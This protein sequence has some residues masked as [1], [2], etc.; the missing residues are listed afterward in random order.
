MDFS[1]SSTL[2]KKCV[3]ASVIGLLVFMIVPAHAASENIE[4]VYNA[5]SGG[6]KAYLHIDSSGRINA[7]I[8]YIDFI[9]DW[10]ETYEV[11]CYRAPRFGEINYKLNNLYVQQLGNEYYVYSEGNR[12]S[13]VGGNSGSGFEQVRLTTYSG[14][15]MASGGKMS[16][17]LPDGKYVI[18]ADKTTAVSPSRLNSVTC[19]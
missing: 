19:Y 2:S 8:K 6:S 5:S 11:T 7:Y 9:D 14:L 13:W 10:D 17:S 4:G 12:I 18:N 1:I 3:K 16:V 15:N